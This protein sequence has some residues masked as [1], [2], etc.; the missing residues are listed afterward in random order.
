VVSGSGLLVVVPHRSK[1]DTFVHP[2]DASDGGGQLDRRWPFH[3]YEAYKEHQH[4]R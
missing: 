4:G 1:D 2:V 3:G